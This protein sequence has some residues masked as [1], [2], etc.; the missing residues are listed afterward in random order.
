MFQFFAVSALLMSLVTAQQ[1]SPMEEYLNNFSPLLGSKYTNIM[2][3]LKQ[4][5]PKPAQYGQ[6]ESHEEATASKSANFQFTGWTDFG[7]CTKIC[8][9]GSRA[10]SRSCLNE[11]GHPVTID[12]CFTIAP[13]GTFDL[14]K[15]V[16]YGSEMMETDEELCNKH[17]CSVSEWILQ[18]SCSQK[19]GGGVMTYSRTC[20]DSMDQNNCNFES[21]KLVPCNK[22][23]CFRV[24]KWQEW[25]RCTAPCGGGRSSRKRNCE[26][27]VPIHSP[28]YGELAY[29]LEHVSKPAVLRSI[30]HEN[31]VYY[32]SQYLTSCGAHMVQSRF[33]NA[34]N[35][36]SCPM[37]QMYQA[38]KP[39]TRICKT[40]DITNFRNIQIKLPKVT[41]NPNGCG[42]ICIP[43]C[44]CPAHTPLLGSDGGCYAMDF[45][46]PQN[47]LTPAQKTEMMLR[48]IME[49]RRTTPAPATTNKPSYYQRALST[50]KT[51][52]TPAIPATAK[53]KAACPKNIL[54]THDFDHCECRG[55]K[56]VYDCLTNKKC[57]FMCMDA[58]TCPDAKSPRL[59]SIS[60]ECQNYQKCNI[61]SDCAEGSVCCDICG[62]RCLKPA[63]Y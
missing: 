58:P 30:D 33:C 63:V 28:L 35:C 41:Y 36:P 61:N 20:Y 53:P 52:T 6:G 51:T 19:C 18:K 22:D 43:G 32:F 13:S 23:P 4:Q 8:G 10:R 17:E 54:I 12:N 40:M 60:N 57:P 15:L 55:E 34:G 21:T 5:V 11:T 49:R 46:C 29:A 2:D 56:Q 47:H 26:P 7:T 59:K 38:C 39:C 50:K 16:K 62:G 37:N 3:N 9:G 42:G 44:G 27:N 14:F 24:G 1:I 48:M 45:F 25:S 31:E